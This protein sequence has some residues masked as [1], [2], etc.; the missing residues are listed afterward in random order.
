MFDSY[1][2]GGMEGVVTN[3]K[4]IIVFYGYIGLF[5]YVLFCFLILI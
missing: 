5:I 2:D 4:I 1:S 3:D